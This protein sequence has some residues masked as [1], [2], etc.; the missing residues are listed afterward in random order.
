MTAR[1]LVVD[2]EPDLEPLILQ[3]FRRQIGSGE[4]N[5]AF[6]RDGEE[7]IA[8]LENDP[9][10]DVVLSDI[11][12]PVMDGLTLLGRLN[13]MPRLLKT[14]MVS[15]YTDMLNLRIAMNRGAYDFVTKPI[16]FA[17]LEA[18]IHKTARELEALRESRRLRE[19]LSEIQAELDVA[20]RIQKSLLPEPLA[21]HPRLDIAAVMLPA[22]Q[23]SGDFYDFFALGRGRYGFVVGDVSGKGIPAALFMAVTRTILRSTALH[24][25]S[26]AECLAA[27]NRALLPQGAGQMYATLF[28]GILD[29]ENGKLTWSVGGHQPPWIIPSHGEPRQ[30]E[31][32]RG[33][34]V[35]MFEDAT[36]Q[37]TE[38]V[39]G[40]GDAILVHTDG[41][42]DAESATDEMF[43]KKRLAHL[44]RSLAP[45]DDEPGR[46]G[47]IDIA[48][49]IIEE[50][51]GFTSGA[52]QADDI[53]LL[54]VR[55]GGPE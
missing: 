13:Q 19:E 31:G 49:R 47:I 17:D 30:V 16:D 37:C 39:L 46:P 51:R 42:T 40:A 28:Y 18:T 22:R 29:T 50:V 35:G 1:I 33:F 36:F 48:Q 11:N 55:Y 52:P 26:P 32:P 24:N 3:R 20:A 4:M 27:V 10:I 41:I 54:A 25:A 5:F 2:D 12:M 53:T 43:G 9:A 23:V 21:S 38:T 6:A 8:K 7:A 45:A 34:M 15:A 44:I 14:V